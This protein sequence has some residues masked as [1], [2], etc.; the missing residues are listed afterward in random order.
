MRHIIIIKQIRGDIKMSI[1]ELRKE[2]LQFLMDI[3]EYKDEDIDCVRS[4]L[5][6]IMYKLD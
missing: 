4:M 1:N 2:L 5:Y 3:N 6:E